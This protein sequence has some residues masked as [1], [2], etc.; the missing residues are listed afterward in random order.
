MIKLPI[1]EYLMKHKIFSVSKELVDQYI[2]TDNIKTIELNELY[3]ETFFSHFL[4][5]AE[6]TSN[7]VDYDTFLTC[8]SVAY[9]L[10]GNTESIRWMLKGIGIDSAIEYDKETHK[11][12]IILNKIKL[13]SSA[14][15]FSISMIYSTLYD[16][17]NYL[18]YDSEGNNIKIIELDIQVMLYQDFNNVYSEDFRRIIHPTFKSDINSST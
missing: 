15:S 8:M 4:K 14:N 10:I 11:L 7:E 9:Y 5:L 2:D 13:Y 16:C 12:N 18:I 1:D 3:A 6:L 17:I